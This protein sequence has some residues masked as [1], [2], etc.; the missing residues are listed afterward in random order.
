MVDASLWRRLRSAGS[1]ALQ[2]AAG[3]VW[4]LLQA[5]AA[6]TVAWL[7]ARHGF[8]HKQPFFAAIAA[9]VGLNTTL[10]Q[11][12]LNALR[13][14]QGVVVGIAVGELTLVTVGGG[15]GPLALAILVATAAARAVGGARIAVAQAAVGAILVVALSD[16]QAG[17]DRM[18]DALIGAGVALVFSQLLFSPEPLAL[19]RH[20]EAAALEGMAE[21]LTLLARALEGDDDELAERALAGL[22][23]LPGALAE[24]SVMRHASSHVADRSVWRSRR[25]LVVRE[26]E[27]A[28]YLDM[29]GGSCLLLARFAPSLPADERRT[30]GSRVR[31]L[32]E[33]LTLLAGELGDRATRQRSAD[34]AFEVAN[35][36]SGERP[37]A[38]S[39]P[40]L[41]VAAVR[42]VAT[43]IMVFAGVDLEDAVEA[44]R[45]GILD[46]RVAAP[47][48]VRPGLWSRLRGRR[49]R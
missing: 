27:N 2:R 5:T 3:D 47:A 16:A 36:V 43:D 34:R 9:F 14:L 6:A 48:P 15:S 49:R 31:D 8:G 23:D 4:P 38:D 40:A 37:A 35:A 26:K 29:L 39:A 22:R 30:F 42:V 44:V 11:R 46:Q 24:L 7:I 41:A 17:V 1:R 33:V 32:A 45:A 20:S 19:L 13:L 18:S 21:G 12:G 25:A 10:G 28:G